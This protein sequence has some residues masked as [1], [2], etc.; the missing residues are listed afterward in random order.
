MALT[1]TGRVKNCCSGVAIGILDGAK[2]IGEGHSLCIEPKS[3]M[4][5]SCLATSRTQK[6][7]F[8]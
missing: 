6:R 8:E 1:K 7:E 3:F 4:L 2:E 5:I